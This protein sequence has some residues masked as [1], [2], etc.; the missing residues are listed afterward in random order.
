MRN[1]LCL[2]NTGGDIQVWSVVP[3][4][5]NHVAGD[6]MLYCSSWPWSHLD[7]QLYYCTMVLVGNEPKVFPVLVCNSSVS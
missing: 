5:R 3:V 2:S 6:V 1:V 4:R 7:I